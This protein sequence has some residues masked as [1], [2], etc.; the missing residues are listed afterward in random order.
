MRQCLPS[1]Q[2][3][4]FLLRML[5]FS[6]VIFGHSFAPFRNKTKYDNQQIEGIVIRDVL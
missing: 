1:F 2:N 5:F 4:P 3:S 6:I